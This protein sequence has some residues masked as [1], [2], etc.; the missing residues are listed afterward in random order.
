MCR[1]ARVELRIHEKLLCKTSN[2]LSICSKINYSIICNM[3]ESTKFKG[4]TIFA[5]N[6]SFKRCD[7]TFELYSVLLRLA[8]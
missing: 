1:V 2:I 7:Q 8:G 5:S 4:N 3:N 6:Q